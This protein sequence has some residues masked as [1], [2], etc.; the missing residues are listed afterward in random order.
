M[1]AVLLLKCVDPVPQRLD[2]LSFFF[3]FSSFTTLI[4][5]N[6]VV[7]KLLT[8]NPKKKTK[9]VVIEN[10]NFPSIKNITPKIC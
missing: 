1:R 10:P 7:G 4:Q 5:S 9:G 3:S 6:K 8:E 2:I